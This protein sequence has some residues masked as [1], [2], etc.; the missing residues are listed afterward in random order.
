MTP[1]P[2]RWNLA[3]ATAPALSA[4]MAPPI[5]LVLKPSGQVQVP[6]LRQAAQHN[7]QQGTLMER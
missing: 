5:Q 4:D 1:P 6:S 2:G 7:G 3:S